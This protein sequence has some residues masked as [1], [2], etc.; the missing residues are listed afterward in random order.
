MGLFGWRA[1]SRQHDRRSRRYGRGIA[2][3]RGHALR[4]EPLEQRTV[5]SV[6]L[7]PITGPDAN[8]VFDIPSGKDLYVPLLGTDAGQTVSYSA[9]SS[10]PSVKVSVL[11]GNPTL[12][13][14]VH[15][16]TA[17]NQ[18][19]SGT[20]TFQLFENIAP[21]TVQGI[22]NQVTAG[23]YNNATF[24]RM[25]TASNFQLI[26]GGI[27][28]S[29]AKSDTTV[30][31][32]EFNV[33]ASFNSSGLLAMANAGP[34]TATSEFF[35]T[36]PNRPLTDD[37]QG[38]NYGYT[39]FG[40]ILTGLDIYN[41]ILNVPTSS[42]GGINFANTPVTIDS[43][44][45]ITDTQHGV[46]Q[47]SEPN[48]FT[49]TA[50]ITV[51]ATG[52]DSTTAQQGFSVSAAPTTA[53]T[54]TQPLILNS[55]GNQ[56]TNVNAPVSFQLQGS[57]AA[58]GSMTFSVTGSSSWT[59]TPPNVTVQVVPGSS[60]VATVTLTP[61]TGF[62]GTVNLVAHVDDTANGLHDAQA[63]TL[64]VGVPVSITSVTN[65]IKASNVHSV[66]VSGTSG[67]GDSISL[68]AGDG[69]NT[70]TAA[71]TTVG[72]NGIWTIT[73][74]D[75]SSLKDG[76]IT[77][78]ATATD[79]SNHTGQGT[80]TAS[81]D[82]VPPTVSVTT[83]TNPV[84]SG[85]LTSATASGTASTG[86]NI[87]LVVGDGTHTTTAKTTT[88][89][90]NG[91][92]SI[93]GIDLTALTDGTITYTATAS[94]TVGNTAQSTKTATKDTVNPV[95][96]ITS[97]SNPVTLANVKNTTVAGTG[98]SGDAISVVATDGTHTTT[99]ATATVGSNNSWTITGLDVSA[100]NDG[101]MT[102]KVT[103]T[104]TSNNTA[105]ASQTATKGTVVITSVTSPVNASNVT[106]TTVSGTGQVSATISLVATDGTHTTT[107]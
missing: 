87:S 64:T 84:N 57:D 67:A 28:K 10:N 90:S 60:G 8:S 30:L 17:N 98:E 26:Q 79:T 56:T 5:L 92:W 47:I 88:A 15:G 25:E 63:F 54:S 96:A 18:A 6:S 105:T 76:T 16:T 69:T 45:M 9:T 93:T 65:P 36:A 81:K 51:T 82:T 39:I 85:N 49:G 3:S 106:A 1:C 43:A 46:L 100:L 2:L 21:Q 20:M 35:I 38:L 27:E 40:Q 42:S 31:P 89:D 71:L 66:S 86:A 14:T 62:V 101:T 7:G 91:A 12:S 78:T 70:T 34:N 24:Y 77:F 83:V 59:A 103:E 52:T 80:L 19:F 73:G 48:N 44:S 13:M 75:V 32:D 41:D 99:A 53:A 74:L 33:S 4:F 29:P 104:D 58:T 50:S 68:V 97:A 72:S 102:Y 61:A 37:P 11:T 94:D 23:L 22:I 95:V 107:H 55:V